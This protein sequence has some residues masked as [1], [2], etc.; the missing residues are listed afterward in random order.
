MFLIRL[1]KIEISFPLKFWQN[2][3]IIVSFFLISHHCH[4][5]SLHLNYWSI[6][7]FFY[8]Y[9]LILVFSNLLAY[10]MD[11]EANICCNNNGSW[12]TPFSLINRSTSQKKRKRNNRVNASK[13]V[14]LTDIYTFYATATECEFFSSVHGSFLRIDHMVD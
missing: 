4:W 8:L 13:Q 10:G 5:F 6:Y 1:R 12:N 3:T 14:V 11:R 9:V 2:S 7:V